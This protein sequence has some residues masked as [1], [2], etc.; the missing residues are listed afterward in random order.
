MV[1]Q[2]PFISAK[3]I[4]RLL[5]E[6]GEKFSVRRIQEILQKV[7]Y[8][9]RYTARNPLLTERMKM[10]R[11]DFATSHLHWMSEMWFKVMFPDESTFRLVSPQEATERERKRDRERCF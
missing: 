10:Q 2:R 4:K 5:G 9:S 6:E 7:W 8:N 1:Q 3:T 11:M